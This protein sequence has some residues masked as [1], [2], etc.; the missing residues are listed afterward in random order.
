MVPGLLALLALAAPQ[1][2]K[3]A[4][5]PAPKPEWPAVKPYKLNWRIE[6]ELKLPDLAGQEH[7][8]FA[9]NKDKVVV[10]VFW[11]YRDPVSLFYA[12]ILSEM[13]AKYRGSSRSTWSTRTRRGSRAATTR[14]ATCARP[15][16]RPA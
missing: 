3:P 6:G 15:C 14:S 12:P 9:E 1:Q 10:L 16:R 5:V 4:V 13:Q 7:A 8:L 11:S 2:V